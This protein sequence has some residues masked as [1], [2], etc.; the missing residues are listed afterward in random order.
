MEYVTEESQASCRLGQHFQYLGQLSDIPFLDTA[1]A[2]RL[3]T[4][5][6]KR[7]LVVLTEEER[8]SLTSEVDN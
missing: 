6:G 4:F 1:A 8:L 7:A 2:S 3:I 5:K